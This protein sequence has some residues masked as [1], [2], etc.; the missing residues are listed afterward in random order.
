M[1]TDPHS[2]GYWLMFTFCGTLITWLLWQMICILDEWHMTSSEAHIAEHAEEHLRYKQALMQIES[3]SC[4]EAQCWPL[5]K[6]AR[7]ALNP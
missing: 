5:T 6:I 7:D 2:V 3:W 1:M 4:N